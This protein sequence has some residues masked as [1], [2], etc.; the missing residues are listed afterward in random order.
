MGHI[1]RSKF[2]FRSNYPWRNLFEKLINE[3]HEPNKEYKILFKKDEK[4]KPKLDE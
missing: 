2:L 1:E 4:Q 3:K